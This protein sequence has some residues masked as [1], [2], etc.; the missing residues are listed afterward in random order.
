MKRVFIN[1]IGQISFEK[2]STSTHKAEMHCT[3]P[4]EYQNSAAEASYNASC[5]NDIEKMDRDWAYKCSQSPYGGNT[6]Y[7]FENVVG[8]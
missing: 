3:N 8:V 1:R 2:N 4:R 7:W 5:I 6:Q